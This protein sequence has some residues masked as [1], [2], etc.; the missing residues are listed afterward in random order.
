M[1][2]EAA[3]TA[4]LAPTL[5]STLSSLTFPQPKHSCLRMTADSLAGFESGGALLWGFAC[6]D[7]RGITD[8]S[9]INQRAPTAVSEM[10]R[11]RGK[12]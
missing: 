4:V 9:L 3:F 7:Q 1:L 11:N 10:D 8:S 6:G 12:S 2:S 5:L